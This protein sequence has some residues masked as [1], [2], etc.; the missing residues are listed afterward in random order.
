[1]RV[2]DQDARRRFEDEMVAHSKRFARPL[3]EV[4][5]D[6]QVRTA[7]HEAFAR[8]EQY[9]FTNRG[10]IRLFVELMFLCGS[11][12]DTDPQYA[13]AGEI[14]QGPEDQMFRAQQLHVWHN[15]YLDQVSGPAAVNVRNA[16]AE[17]LVFA[18]G[19]IS[20]THERLHRDLMREMRRIFPAKAEYA[21][22]PALFAIVDESIV[23]ARQLQF[24]EARSI[25]LLAVLKFAFGHGCTRDPLYPWIASTLQDDRMAT[26][27]NRA[28]RLE[29]KAITWLEHVVARNQEGV[30][31]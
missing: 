31:S 1:M 5:G 14:L 29:K 11:A 25:V 30:K 18:Q 21:G 2:F 12:F 6:V 28:A 17:L 9:K 15:E 19:P 27:A 10:P 26:P 22:E 24:E 13:A 16:L 23:E 8:S 20:C 3:C 4:I 7:V